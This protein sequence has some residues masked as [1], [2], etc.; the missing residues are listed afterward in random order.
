[1]LIVLMRYLAFMGGRSGTEG[2][3]I[4]QQVLE[5]NPVLQAFGNAKMVKNNN[6]SRFGKFV[7]IQFDKQGKISRAVVRTYL[8]ERSRVCQVSDPEMNYHCFYMI[9]ADVKRFKL[10]DPRKFHYLNRTNC[11]EVANID[12]GRVY[13][14]TRNAINVIGINQDEQVTNMMKWVGL[15]TKK[16][17]LL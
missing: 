9:C 11:Y 14:E 13:L 17:T 4:E 1:M 6:S 8:L 12:D 5:S 10:G 3:T 16:S 7:E 2:R 15:K